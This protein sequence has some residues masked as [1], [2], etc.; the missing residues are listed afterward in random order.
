MGSR[1][2]QQGLLRADDLLGTLVRT[3]QV[4]WIHCSGVGVQEVFGREGDFARAKAD[5]DDLLK[6]GPVLR[7]GAQNVCIAL[8]E[9]YIKSKDSEPRLGPPDISTTR[10][11]GARE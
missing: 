11:R 8:P 7:M 1:H 9:G 4:G 6:V 2:A 5:V 10:R 3:Q